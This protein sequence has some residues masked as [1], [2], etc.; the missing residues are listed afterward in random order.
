MP[1]TQLEKFVQDYLVFGNAYLEVIPNSFGHPLTLKAPLAKYMRV[2]VKEGIFYQV[3]NGIDEHEF[4]KGSVFHL[5]NPDINQEIYG[6]PDYLGALQSAYLNESATLFRRKYYINGAHAGS[7]I[8][9][10][11]PTQTKDDVDEIKAQ[12]KQTKGTGNFKNTFLK[13]KKTGYR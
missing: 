6:M 2:G 1:R 12:L 10:T 9:F 13:V 5:C 4:K 11:D 3:V 8:Y 7:I